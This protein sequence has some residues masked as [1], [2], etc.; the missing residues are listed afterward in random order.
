M[1]G[2]SPKTFSVNAGRPA[3]AAPAESSGGAFSSSG[4]P[5]PASAWLTAV[6]AVSEASAEFGSDASAEAGGDRGVAGTG[7]DPIANTAIP[8]TATEIR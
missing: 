2:A 8:Q 6:S 3:T 1:N 7:V 5:P 4:V